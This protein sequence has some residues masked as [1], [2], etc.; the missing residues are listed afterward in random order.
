MA[1]KRAKKAQRRKQ[2]AAL[3]KRDDAIH[4]SLPAR[5]ARAAQAPIQHCYINEGLF[6]IGLG[7]LVLSRG[8]TSPLGVAVFL[9][10][11]FALGV[12]DVMF[13]F[14]D[15]QQV[16]DYLDM[17]DSSSTMVPVAPSEARKLLRELA[18]WSKGHG[19]APHRDF[20]AVEKIFGDVNADDS[21]AVFR[22]GKDGKP[23]LISG[24][25]DP[26]AELLDD[27]AWE[28]ALADQS[29]PDG[30]DDAG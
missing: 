15:E 6:E 24:P 10:D 18:A 26:D 7:T 25:F 4:N 11:T 27:E 14:M 20:V 8:H 5:V 16:E 21:D 3:A 29:E 13:R 19:F 23:V 2:L 22:F 28:A 30:R 17:A 1:Q 9:L 12:K